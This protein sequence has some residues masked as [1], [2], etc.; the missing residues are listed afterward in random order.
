MIAAAGIDEHKISSNHKGVKWKS[1][2]KSKGLSI[3]VKENHVHTVVKDKNEETRINVNQ[4]WIF[5]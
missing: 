4:S 2:K 3:I 1:Q 5:L